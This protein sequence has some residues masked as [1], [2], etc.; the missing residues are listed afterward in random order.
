[1]ELEHITT[2]RFLSKDSRKVELNMELSTRQTWLKL[3][4]EHFNDRES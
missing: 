4:I 1:M 3:N 2:V